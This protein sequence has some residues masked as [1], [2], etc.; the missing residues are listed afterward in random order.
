MIGWESSIDRTRRTGLAGGILCLTVALISGNGLLR[1]A[2]PRVHAN[3][4]SI[5][6]HSFTHFVPAATP[7]S[8]SRPSN[9]LAP[10]PKPSAARPQAEPEP[11]S[12]NSY[13]NGLKAAGLGDFTVDQLIAMKIQG[14]TPEYVRDLHGLNY[15]PT[16]DQLV[17][18]R[19]QRVTQDYVRGLRDTGIQPT[20]DQLIAMR[21][22]G[23]TPEYVRAMHEQGL[24]PDANKLVAMRIQD[25]TA[26]Y[27]REL[28]ALGM[29]ATV[30]QFIS[31]KIQGVTADYIKGLEA[32][33]LTLSVDDVITAKI[34]QID[35]Q[36]V[37]RAVKHGF[38]NLTVEKLIQLKNL[39]VLGS[40]ADI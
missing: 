10:A 22:Q 18:M 26:D 20:I 15:T 36:F 17:A 13:I 11:G 2:Q 38:R 28:Q 21:I 8:L 27:V 1:I 6:Q 12:S 30:D 7:Q 24:Q 39:G 16:A 9:P 37:Q 34:Q 29:K 31:M 40:Q 19:I 4:A 3:A 14:V 25:V 5:A 35:E 32:A 23:V 33:G